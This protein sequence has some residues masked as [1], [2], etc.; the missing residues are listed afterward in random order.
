[1]LTIRPAVQEDILVLSEFW[2]DN[3]ALM[4]QSNPR[5]RLLPDARHQWEVAMQS[6]SVEQNAIFLVAENA[7]ELVGCV[8]GR[9]TAN[10]PGLAPERIGVIDTLLLD[11]HSKKLQ[12]AGRELLQAVKSRFIDQH[13][14][15]LQV[16]VAAQA[17]VAQAFWLG[18]GAK[19]TDE[20]FWMLL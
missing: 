11:L 12:G 17:T 20:I 13:V 19:K 7:A 1:M 14:S 8:I 15:Q 4:Q 16:A 10:K 2:Y 3:M 6:I 9:V 18:M 5:I